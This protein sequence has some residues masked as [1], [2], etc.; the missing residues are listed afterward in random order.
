MEESLRYYVQNL[1]FEMTKKWMEEGK[2]RWCWL[3][4]GDTALMLQELGKQGHDSWKP[5]CKVGEGVTICFMCEEALAIYRD[6]VSRGLK[7]SRNPFVGNRLWG[8]VFLRP[9]WLPDRFREPYGRSRGDGVLAA[10]PLIRN[11]AGPKPAL[12]P[13]HFAE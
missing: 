11:L 4:I 1:G 10:A 5:S 7:A 13:K 2:L 8:R 9:R 3:E 6:A 12:R